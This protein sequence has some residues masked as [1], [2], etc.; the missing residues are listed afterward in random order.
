[1]SSGDRLPTPPFLAGD[2]IWAFKN[3]RD[4]G[5]RIVFWES[6][7]AKITTTI[8]Q[9]SQLLI[10]AIVEG[11][12]I[13]IRPAGQEVGREIFIVWPGMFTKDPNLAGV[14]W[15]KPIAKELNELVMVDRFERSFTQ[16]I[17]DGAP[18]QQLGDEIVWVQTKL[19]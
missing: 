10:Y 8:P 14:R 18:S 13:G 9:G 12:D 15:T 7:R 11:F 5:G 16:W 6:E 4:G 2:L 19:Q 3:V 1:M 17:A